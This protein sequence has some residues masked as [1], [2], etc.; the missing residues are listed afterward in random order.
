MLSNKMKT[1]DEVG[2]P[3]FLKK[4]SHILTSNFGSHFPS[5]PTTRYLMLIINDLGIN[6]SKCIEAISIAKQQ[7]RSLLKTLLLKVL[8]LSDIQQIR[9]NLVSQM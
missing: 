2:S 4:H 9:I 3:V 5:T 6:K 8:K 1:S 7:L